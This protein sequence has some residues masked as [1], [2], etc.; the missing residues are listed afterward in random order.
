MKGPYLVIPNRVNE[1]RIVW[2]LKVVGFFTRHSKLK[3]SLKIF[4]TGSSK[5]AL[6]S[7]VEKLRVENFYLKLS[8]GKLLAI[9]ASQIV[10]IS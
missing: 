5:D 2:I 4:T 1:T 8:I 9:L 3:D 10:N 7:R 6:K